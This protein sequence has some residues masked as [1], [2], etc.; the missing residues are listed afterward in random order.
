[1]K[2]CSREYQESIYLP[3]REPFAVRIALGVVNIEAQ[4]QARLSDAGSVPWSSGELFD[5]QKVLFP[6]ATYEQDVV[7]AGEAFYFPPEADRKS[8][9]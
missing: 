7:S 1:M 4:S 6:Y 8:V 3:V 9:V 2:A 5:N